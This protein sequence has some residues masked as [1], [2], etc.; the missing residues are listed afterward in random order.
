MIA[1]YIIRELPASSKAQGFCPRGAAKQLW[2]CKEPAAIISGSAETGKTF[3]A[4]H[5]LDARCWKYPGVQAAIIRKTYNSAVTSVLQTFQNKVLGRD[6][7]VKVHGGTSPQF[8]EYPNGSKIF[9]G[10]MDNPNKVLSSERDFIFIN[11][12]EELTEP[13]FEILTTR[14]TG[15]AGNAPYAQV[16]GD[17]NPSFPQHWIKKR[18]GLT[19]FESRHE[20]NPVLFDDAGKITQQGRR[21]LA[22]LDALTGPRKQRLRYGRW[23]QAEG[24]VYE[25]WDAAVHFKTAAELFPGGRV[26]QEWPR[27]LVIDFGF[28]HPFVAQW[29]AADGDG[30]LYLY[31]EIYLTQT[32]VEDHA[33]EIKAGIVTDGKR[34]Q[35]I[36]CDHDAEDRATLERHLGQSTS[37]APKAVSPGIQAMAGR[38]KLQNDGKPRLFVM[39]DSLVR[40]DTNLHDAK[41]PCCFSDEIDTYIWNDS[42]RKDEPIKEYDHSMDAARYIV[43]HLDKRVSGWRMERI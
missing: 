8:Y 21:T 38:L 29:W 36:L 10:G 14:A 28:V 32:L 16:F 9:V 3:A 5:L 34:P 22:V 19:L 17:C 37:P 39:R 15:R 35:L 11:Q 12:A 27:Y 31:R 1:T 13:E 18:S 24:V 2:K 40:R 26:P 6:S 41:K 25:G 7:P 20:D 43:Y 42:I 33:K 30:R 23:V 4:L